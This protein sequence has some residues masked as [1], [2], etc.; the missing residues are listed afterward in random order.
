MTLLLT[1]DR[2][3]T[4]EFLPVD[5]ADEPAPPSA[6]PAG[7]ADREPRPRYSVEFPT[8]GWD[9]AQLAWQSLSPELQQ[10]IR[11]A[12]DRGEATI[13]VALA[14]PVG[15]TRQAGEQRPY[16]KPQRTA[17]PLDIEPVAIP[18]APFDDTG[19]DA[20]SDAYIPSPW[21]IV[22][23]AAEIRAGWTPAQHRTAL[24]YSLK[25][26]VPRARSRLGPSCDG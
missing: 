17:P 11:A 21:E 18:V 9:C 22:A 5:L 7:A 25:W 6:P 14:A 10:R 23:T 20:E 8:R 4:D 12:A 24:G 1:D 26:R 13:I 3:T 16:R 2:V 19:M 15:R